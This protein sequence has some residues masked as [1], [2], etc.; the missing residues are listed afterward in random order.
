ML[1][2]LFHNDKINSASIDR[3]SDFARRGGG[4]GGPKMGG[5]GSAMG[6]IAQPNNLYQGSWGTVA[7]GGMGAKC[8]KC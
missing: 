6:C 5:G 1:G 7:N 8:R 3:L 2:M 4:G